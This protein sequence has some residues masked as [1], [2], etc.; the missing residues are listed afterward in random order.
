MSLPI[1]TLELFKTEVSKFSNYLASQAIPELFGVTD[2]KA[3]GTFIEHSLHTWL[4]I[5]YQ[6]AQGNSASGIDFPRLN[7]DLKV[8]SVKQ[9]QS[10]SPFRDASQKI[11]GLG[12]DL[13]VMVYAKKDDTTQKLCWLNFEHLIYISKESTGDY[14]TTLGILRILEQNGNVDDI[15]AFLEERHLPL[16]SD[17]RLQLAKRVLQSP[18]LLGVLTISNA[19]QWRLQYTRAITTAQENSVKGVEDLR[20]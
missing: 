15:D 19:L 12:Y 16:D 11:Y 2:G 20:G 4:G 7:L 10:S 17:S 6:L 3:V 5:R 14:Q 8:T 9:P 1:L 18:P 13:L